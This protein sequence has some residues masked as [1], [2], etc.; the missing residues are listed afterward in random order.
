MCGNDGLATQ[1][2]AAPQQHWQAWQ[3]LMRSMHAQV[4]QYVSQHFGFDYGF[5]GWLVLIMLGWVALFRVGAILA[6]TKL[7]FVKR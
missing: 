4:A 5:R 7:S 1:D 3:R 2:P 6:V